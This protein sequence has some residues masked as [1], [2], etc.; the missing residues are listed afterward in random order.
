MLDNYTWEA[1]L[2]VC[3]DPSRIETKSSRVI[4]SGETSRSNKSQKE[5]M[6]RT[7]TSRDSK[8]TEGGI[9]KEAIGEAGS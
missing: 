7:R 1:A 3:G 9:Q 4:G 6:C 8:R 2:L 5:S